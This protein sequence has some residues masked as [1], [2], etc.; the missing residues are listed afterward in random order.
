M[1]DHTVFNSDGS[2]DVDASVFK[3]EE[4]LRTWAHEREVKLTAVQAAV[5]AILTASNGARVAFEKLV[6]L[7]LVKLQPTMAAYDAEKARI[8][9]FIRMNTSTENEAKRYTAQKG[10]GGG[11]QLTEQPKPATPPESASKETRPPSECDD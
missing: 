8:E 9:S 6:N 3:Y 7:S 11:Y 1:N 2:V 10:K 4:A 5:D